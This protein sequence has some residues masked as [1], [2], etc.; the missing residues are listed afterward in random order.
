MSEAEEVKKVCEVKRRGIL[1]AK[2]SERAAVLAKRARFGMTS[3]P[4][5]ANSARDSWR[6]WPRRIVPL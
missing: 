3:C 1:P 5:F 4:L 6:P 2:G